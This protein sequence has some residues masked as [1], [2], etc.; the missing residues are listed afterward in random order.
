M[1]CKFYPCLEYT[2]AGHWIK[3]AGYPLVSGWNRSETDTVFQIPVAYPGTP[4]YGIFVPA[5]ILFNSARPNNYVEP[6]GTQPPFPGPWGFF[7]WAPADGE[8][9]PT[10]NVT[11][12]SNLLNWVHGFAE[13]FK[14]GA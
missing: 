7:S 3:I 4:P 12:G 2:E 5:G 13:R 11:S 1:L 8:W 14:E 6:A 9:R 10:A